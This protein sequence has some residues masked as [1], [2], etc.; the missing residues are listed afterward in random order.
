V[1]EIKICGITNRDDAMRASELEVD[2]I[3]FIFYE[4]SP[5]AVLSEC[6]APIVD[7]LAGAVK[8]VGVFV[9]ESPEHIAGVC[10]RCGLYAAQLHGAES[11][12]AFAA[13]P[14]RLWRSVRCGAGHCRPDPADWTVERFVVDA[15]VP[16]RYG[17]T[18]QRA[19]W[20]KAEA[21][22]RRYPVMLAGGLTS[23]NVTQAIRAVGPRGVD[24]VSG[25]EQRPGI[26]D[27]VKL[28]AFVN[29]VR[30]VD[31]DASREA[32]PTGKV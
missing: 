4:R 27:P 12:G 9:D 26:K 25:T 1:T 8:P 19:D 15:D 2:F 11:P 31:R 5:R 21:L 29:A 7:E 30:S 17:G 20:T 6:V 23:D 10:E 13:L 28:E 24:V 16:G 18:G 14:L 3:G 32:A 22:A